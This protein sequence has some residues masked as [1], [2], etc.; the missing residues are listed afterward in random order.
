MGNDRR[1]MRFNDK[2]MKGKVKMEIMINGKKYI[3]YG[4]MEESLDYIAFEVEYIKPLED[5]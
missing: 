3:I 1:V 2:A 5:D 4:F